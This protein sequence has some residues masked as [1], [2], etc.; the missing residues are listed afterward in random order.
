MIDE[1]TEGHNLSSN[2]KKAQNEPNFITL[3]KI[4]EQE[5]IEIIKLGFQRQAE[6]IISLKKYYESTQ[7]DS[8]FKLK[9]YSIKYETILRTKI[10]QNLKK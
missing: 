4:P 9:G 5:K 1:P 6:G 8:L 3:G 2:P 10:Y 7:K